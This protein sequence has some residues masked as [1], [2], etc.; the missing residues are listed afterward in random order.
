MRKVTLILVVMYII[1]EENFRRYIITT[2]LHPVCSVG[3]LQ[4]ISTSLPSPRRK[5]AKNKFGYLLSLRKQ[6]SLEITLLY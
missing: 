1:S 3:I 2:N 4:N 5:P 6:P